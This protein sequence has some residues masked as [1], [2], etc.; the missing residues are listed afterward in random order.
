M[1]EITIDFTYIAAQFVGFVAMA[2][3][4]ISFQSRER[5]K[6]LT[7][8]TLSNFLW[9]ISYLILWEPAAVVAN[10]IGTLR[11]VLYMFRGKYKFA[12]SKAIPV[13]VIT[14]FIISGVLTYQTPFDLLPMFAMVISTIAFFVKRENTIRWL[15]LLVAISWFTFGASA[16]NI[17]SIVSDGTNFLSIVIALIRYRGVYLYENNKGN[18]IDND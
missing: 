14:R 10:S 18:E 7:F 6:I 13:I 17:A 9:V 2:C 5:A 15:S 16:G 3:G 8:Q 12:D 1:L 11:N 4:I